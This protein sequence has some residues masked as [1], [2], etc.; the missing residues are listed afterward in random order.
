MAMF[1]RVAIHRMVGHGHMLYQN[2]CILKFLW[3]YFTLGHTEVTVQK[4]KVD[5]QGLVD[6]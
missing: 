5:Q 3:K 4:N 2:N 6:I 1:Y